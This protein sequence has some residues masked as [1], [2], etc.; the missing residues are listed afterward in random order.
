MDSK[1]WGPYFWF[2]LHSISLSYPDKPTYEIRRQFHDFFINF[3]NVLPCKKC[4]DH[5]RQHLI[6]N[7]IAVSLDSKKSLVL[8]VFN[9]HNQV[10]ISLGKKIYTFEEFQEKYRKIY[11]PTI[12]EQ[13]INNHPKQDY[14][15]SRFIII[16]LICLGVIYYIFIKYKKRKARKLFYNS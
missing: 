1:I 11:S 10:N 3:Q 13:I 9:M 8:W 7:P 4:Q 16:F 2:T 15:V 5:Y 12:P 14:R 6:K